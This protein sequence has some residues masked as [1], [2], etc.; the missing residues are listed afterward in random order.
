VKILPK[1]LIAAGKRRVSEDEGIR[2][3]KRNSHIL[4]KLTPVCGPQ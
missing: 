1:D 4:E 2:T 3:S